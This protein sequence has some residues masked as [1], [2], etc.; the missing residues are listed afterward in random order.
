MEKTY[1]INIQVR[2]PGEQKLLIGHVIMI[3]ASSSLDAYQKA[4]AQ[5]S[6][7]LNKA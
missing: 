2:Y 7:E 6:Q 1:Q 4:I 5:A 3:K